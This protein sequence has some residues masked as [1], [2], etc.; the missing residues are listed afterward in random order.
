MLIGGRRAL[1]EAVGCGLSGIELY[2]ADNGAV[3]AAEWYVHG[4]R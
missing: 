3:V 4:L 1:P 2:I